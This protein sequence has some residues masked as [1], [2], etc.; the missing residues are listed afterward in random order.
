[1]VLDRGHMWRYVAIYPHAH[2]RAFGEQMAATTKAKQWKVD[3]IIDMGLGVIGETVEYMKA[4]PQED[5]GASFAK[6]L[7]AYT[8]AA[9]EISKELREASAFD[10]KHE[11]DPDVMRDL[12]QDYLRAMPKEEFAQMIMQ[13]RQEPQQGEARA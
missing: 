10:A 5:R 11:I 13:V 7:T 4:T 6:D 2:A 1:M 3:E 12:I 9:C 8:R